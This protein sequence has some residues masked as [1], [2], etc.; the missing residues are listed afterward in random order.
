MRADWDYFDE[1]E[2]ERLDARMDSGGDEYDIQEPL[3]C[4]EC[5]EWSLFPNGSEIEFSDADGRRGVRV[6][7]TICS[8][9]GY[10]G[11]SM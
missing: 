6:Y 5:G 9:C 2:A 3:T 7:Y 10:E 11:E 8:E 1:L 4:P